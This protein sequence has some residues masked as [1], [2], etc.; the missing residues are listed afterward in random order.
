MQPFCV[1]L[2][3]LYK[4]YRYG[5]KLLYKFIGFQLETSGEK[6]TGKTSSTQAKVG[7]KGNI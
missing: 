6:I 7:I 3:L 4:K 2:D 5:Q 1:V